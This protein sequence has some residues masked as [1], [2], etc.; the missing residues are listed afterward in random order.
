MAK[1]VDEKG[2]KIIADKIKALNSKS[3]AAGISVPA[4]RWSSNNAKI[5][6]SDNSAI[7][8]V[9]ATSYLE[10]SPADDE[11]AADYINCGIRVTGQAAGSITLSCTTVPTAALNLTLIIF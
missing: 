7:L 5:T 3:L 2:A 4:S 9:T 10:V 6:S 8:S 11:S 1:F